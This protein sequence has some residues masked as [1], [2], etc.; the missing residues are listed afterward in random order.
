MAC[1]APRPTF[2]TAARPKR[3]APS[4]TVNVSSDAFTSGGSTLMPIR[5]ASATAAATFSAL[6]ASLLSTAAMYSTG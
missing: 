5:C 4:A 1:T 2:F 3:M 6:P